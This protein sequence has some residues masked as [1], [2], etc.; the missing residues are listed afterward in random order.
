ML[1][2]NGQLLFTDFGGYETRNPSTIWCIQEADK[3]YLWPEFSEIKIYTGDFEA[4]A[5]NHTYSKQS[6]YNRLVPDFN[7]HS[8][9]QVGIDDYEN[10]TKDIDAAGSSPSLVHKV[11]W[12]GNTNTN[13]M[14]KRLF[15]LGH[16]NPNLLDIFDCGNWWINPDRIQLNS[17]KYISTPELVKQYGILIDVEG[18][19]YSGRLKHLLWSHRPLLLVDRPH[20]EYFFE[21]LREWA[22]YSC[23]SRFVGFGRENDMV[24]RKLR[25]GTT[26]RKKCISV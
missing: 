6:G 16:Q 8:W 15:E 26:Y 24:R 2:S 12:I 13:P 19:G 23:K 9:P 17:H 10:F 20:K 7:F 1:K 18:N 14:R 3:R 22:L 5:T 21:Y 25:R 4:D 11:G